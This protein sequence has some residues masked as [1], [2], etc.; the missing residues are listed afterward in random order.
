MVL[1]PMRQQ[2]RPNLVPVLGQVGDIRNDNIHTQQLFFRKHQTGVDDDNVILPAESH[3]VHAELAEAPQ[4]NH[5]QF[6]L[7]HE[8]SIL[9]PQP[10]PL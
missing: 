7:C 1:V 9:A 2:D 6:I 4:G 5:L 8:S 10:Y 3:A